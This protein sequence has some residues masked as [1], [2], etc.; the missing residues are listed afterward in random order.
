DRLGQQAFRIRWR[1][2][3]LADRDVEIRDVDRRE[4]FLGQR[5]VAQHAA[6]K[7]DDHHGHHHSRH[8]QDALEE[9]HHDGCSALALASLPSAV[10]PI[11]V[12]SVFASTIWPGWTYSCPTVITLMDAG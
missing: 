11:G 1:H 6:K 4:A 10:A 7:Q 12:S 3:R 5:H 2:A 8:A 9:V